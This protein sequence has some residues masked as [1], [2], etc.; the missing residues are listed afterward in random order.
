MTTIDDEIKAIDDSLLTAMGD[1]RVIEYDADNGRAV[2]EFTP[3]PEMCHSGGVVQGGFVTG[4][5]DTAMA[6]A[7]IASAKGER[8]MT[9]LEI[10][11]S[12]LK[13]A[14]PGTTYR[15][16]GCVVRTGKSVMFMEGRLTD[17][18]GTLIAKGSATGQWI[19]PR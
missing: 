7:A 5:L 3:R 10:K 14:Q 17:P 12:F 8:S 19:N 18:D 15:A 2:V 16:E 13:S 4:W 1:G 11:I 6:R 9:T